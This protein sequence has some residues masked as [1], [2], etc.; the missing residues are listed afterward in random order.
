VGVFKPRSKTL[1]EEDLQENDNE[2]TNPIERTLGL[3]E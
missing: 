1:K 2:L 3:N